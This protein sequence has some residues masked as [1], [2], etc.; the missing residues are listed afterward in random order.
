ML[1]LNDNV[2][3]GLRSDSGLKDSIDKFLEKESL[4]LYGDRLLSISD[5]KHEKFHEFIQLN[6][7]DI[8]LT[9]RINLDTKQI[10]DKNLLGFDDYD[11]SY[12]TCKESSYADSP[13]VI[14]VFTKYG[15]IL[16]CF[17]H[18]PGYFYPAVAPNGDV[19]FMG[20]NPDKKHMDFYRIYAVWNQELEN[21]EKESSD[22]IQGP[23]VIG[24]SSSNWLTWDK[25]WYCYHAVKA[26]DGEPGTAWI[27]GSKTDGIDDW[28]S[29]EFENPIT[30]D[31][32]EVSPGLFD[33]RWWKAN[34]RVRTLA[35]EIDG[36]RTEL[37]F[38]DVMMA[39]SVPFKKPKNFKKIKFAISSINKSKQSND[40]AISEITFYYQGRRV[41]LDLSR[42]N[43]YL[44][45]VSEKEVKGGN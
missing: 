35:M 33:K 20:L 37:T 15:E 34:N 28:I 9:N 39:Q 16:D 43:Q 17:Y 44:K 29:L 42:V 3:S 27:E 18:P 13:Y 6:I 8:K 7:K 23:V 1:K 32:I 21:R 5:Y 10:W 41:E 30:I 11:N 24:V 22:M 36:E 12:W 26:F 25:D 31:K 38:K 2:K 19:Y 14:L 40:T 4:F 45:K